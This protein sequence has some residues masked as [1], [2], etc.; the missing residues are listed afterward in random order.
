MLA[1]F[2]LNYTTRNAAKGK[3]AL[4]LLH[5]HSKNVE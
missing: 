1:G 4:P 3:E 5:G 2:A